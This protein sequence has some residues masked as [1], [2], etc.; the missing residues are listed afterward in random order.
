MGQPQHGHMQLCGPGDSHLLPPSLPLSSFPTGKPSFPWTATRP[1]P[2]FSEPVDAHPALMH[3]AKGPQPP[4]ETLPG[5]LGH[6]AS[7]PVLWGLVPEGRAKSP[8]V[9]RSQLPHTGSRQT[10]RVPEAAPAHCSRLTAWQERGLQHPAWLGAPRERTWEWMLAQLCVLVHTSL[11]PEPH[12][13]PLCG[14]RPHA[15]QDAPPPRQPLPPALQRQREHRPLQVE[16]AGPQDR[17]GV[18]FPGAGLSH[19]RSA[20]SKQTSRGVALSSACPTPRKLQQDRAVTGSTLR[21]RVNSP[22]SRSLT[23]GTASTQ[24]HLQT[25]PASPFSP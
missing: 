13:H 8:Q 17:L 6:T 14:A 3:R 4:P 10:A 5:T 9:Q 18:N 11:P 1:W 20:R 25:S 23:R 24:A 12:P 16:A 15:T 7:R 22:H 19:P 21:L 2:R